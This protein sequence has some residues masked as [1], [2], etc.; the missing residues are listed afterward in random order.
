MCEDYLGAAFIALGSAKKK[1][2]K[3]GRHF[4]LKEVKNCLTLLGAEDYEEYLIEAEKGNFKPLETYL[5][6]L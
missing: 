3:N 6:N 4:W 5:L 2:P 1:F